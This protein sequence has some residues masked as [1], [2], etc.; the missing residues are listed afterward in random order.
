M[1]ALTSHELPVE[2]DLTIRVA[3]DG[4]TTLSGRSHDPSLVLAAMLRSKLFERAELPSVE[5]DRY[6][7]GKQFDITAVLSRPGAQMP[8]TGALQLLPDAATADQ[9]MTDRLADVFSLGSKN[10]D[11]CERIS[12][13][14]L[15]SEDVAG[16][17]KAS[18][19]LRLRCTG[20]QAAIVQAIAALEQGTPTLFLSEFSLYHSS[21]PGSDH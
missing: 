15:P 9:S 16:Y 5:E 17:K 12:S 8:S 14:R 6:G 1:L 19:V 13:M 4:F 7:T 18:Q 11:A 10:T 2:L 3:A 20:S 21:S